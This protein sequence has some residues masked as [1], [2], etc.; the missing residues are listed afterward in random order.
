[1]AFAT[2]A[3]TER[4]FQEQEYGKTDFSDFAKDMNPLNV[5]A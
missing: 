2:I 3:H 4:I 1:M 5:N